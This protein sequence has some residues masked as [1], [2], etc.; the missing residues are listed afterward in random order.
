MEN[1][2][3]EERPKLPLRTR[4]S[5]GLPFLGVLIFLAVGSISWLDVAAGQGNLWW[6][7]AFTAGLVPCIWAAGK[8]RRVAL[9]MSLRVIFLLGALG[10]IEHQSVA[11]VVFLGV[12]AAAYFLI[13][14]FWRLQPGPPLGNPESLTPKKSV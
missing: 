13:K 12:V 9:I 7:L 4:L 14:R 3:S 5:I 6:A 1:M 10:A 11:V 8:N 2:K